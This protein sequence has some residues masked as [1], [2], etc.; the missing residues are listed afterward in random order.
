[1]ERLQALMQL[2]EAIQDAEQFGLLRTQDGKVITGA[3]DNELGFE[4][5]G[6]EDSP[7][8]KQA[9]IEAVASELEG[10]L[11]D[12]QLSDYAVNE[13]DLCRCEIN[14]KSYV[15]YLGLRQE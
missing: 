10:L 4:L 9:V 5:V 8:S 12:T 7:L 13:T 14:G 15:L 2:R 3:L 6:D 11:Q 1:M